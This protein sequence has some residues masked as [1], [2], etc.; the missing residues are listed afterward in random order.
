MRFLVRSFSTS[1]S[2]STLVAE[3]PLRSAGTPSSPFSRTSRGSVVEVGNGRVLSPAG[4][5]RRLDGGL[6]SVAEVSA[7]M[8]QEEKWEGEYLPVFFRSC[9]GMFGQGN[10]KKRPKPHTQIC[11]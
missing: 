10:R 2:I 3:D 9:G 6:R 5:G 8:F 11:P 4:A 1:G 7:A